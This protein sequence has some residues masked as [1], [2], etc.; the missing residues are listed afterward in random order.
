MHRD[1]QSSYPNKKNDQLKALASYIPILKSLSVYFIPHPDD[2]LFFSA[3]Q[4]LADVQKKARI[5]FV[6]VTTGDAGCDAS[7]WHARERATLAASATLSIRSHFLRLADGMF[8]G[9]GS[10]LY[11]H[12]SL[13]QLARYNRP[14]DALDKSA[15]YSSWAQFCSALNA[16]IEKESCGIDP[17]AIWIYAPDYD[18]SQSPDDHS[19]HIAVGKAVREVAE[20][21][22]PLGY[23][24]SYWSSYCPPNLSAEKIAAKKELF[25]AY[26]QEIERLTGQPPNTL[27]WDCWGNRNYIRTVAKDGNILQSYGANCPS[28]LQFDWTRPIVENAKYQRSWVAIE[29]QEDCIQNRYNGQPAQLSLAGSAAWKKLKTATTPAE[30]RAIFSAQEPNASP[31]S[32]KRQADY[33][34]RALLKMKL[35]Y[36]AI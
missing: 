28:P 2:W 27:E 10:A 4:V 19:D 34:L 18:P 31:A 16:I 32:C 7:W 36:K 30:L 11:G 17:N 35:I 1:S 21:R 3:S 25:F 6:Y 22:Y 26:S 12:Q 24:L 8:D 14:I 9:H 13:A 23:W 15:T 29:E 5:V 33:L 20:G